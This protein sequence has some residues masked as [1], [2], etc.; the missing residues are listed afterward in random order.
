MNDDGKR[1]RAEEE[2]TATSSKKVTHEGGGAT[3]ADPPRPRDW[4]LGVPGLELVRDFVSREEERAL[5]AVIDASTEWN[6]SLKRRTQHYGYNYDYKSKVVSAG[7]RPLPEWCQYLCDRLVERGLVKVRPD[8]MLVNEYVPGQGI[9]SHIDNK[10]FEDGIVSLSLGSD[11]AMEFVE[12][13]TELKK[14]GQLVRRSALVLHGDAR[15][16]WRHGIAGRKK[17]KGIARHRRLSLTFRRKK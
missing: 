13:A 6:T 11:I 14:E 1:A 7:G 5:M 16:N 10:E 4:F 8:Q 15:Y 9:G 12:V 2:R 17:D 3:A